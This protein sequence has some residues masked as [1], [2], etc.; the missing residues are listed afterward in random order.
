MPRDGGIAHEAVIGG[1]E[2]QEMIVAALSVGG[3]HREKI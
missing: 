2:D 1:A 3:F